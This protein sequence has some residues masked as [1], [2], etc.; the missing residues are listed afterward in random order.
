MKTL[1]VLTS[2]LAYTSACIYNPWADTVSCT[3]PEIKEF[4]NITNI[5]HIDII[6]TS[7]NALPEIDNFP[8]LLSV[9]IENN[10]FLDC[11]DV[12]DLK[13]KASHLV[14]TTDCDNHDENFCHV[15]K[16][17]INLCIDILSNHII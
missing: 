16:D 3:G 1:L 15:N 7:M 10:K 6:N 8:N 5:S 4:P 17:C 13:E 11:Q 12:L 9:V 14:L 2:L